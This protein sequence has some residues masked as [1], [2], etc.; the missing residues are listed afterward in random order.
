MK[1][2]SLVCLCLCLGLPAT[3]RAQPTTTF[4]VDRLVMAGAPGDGFAV[5]RPDMAEKTR[6]FGQLGLGLA[7]NPL[8][9]ENYVDNTYYADKIRGNPLT[10]QLVTYGCGS[11]IVGTEIDRDNGIGGCAAL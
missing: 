3:A 10:A 7:V 8:R 11:L 5:W 4:T 1:K 6:F 9:V 2:L